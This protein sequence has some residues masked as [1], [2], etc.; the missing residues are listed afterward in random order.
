MANENFWNLYPLYMEQPPLLVDPCDGIVKRHAGG[1][2]RCGFWAGYDG[3]NQ[4]GRIGSPGSVVRTAHR[5][6]IAYRKLVDAGKRD[7]LPGA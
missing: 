6:G 3:I 1:S 5:A 4:G 7:P 2:S